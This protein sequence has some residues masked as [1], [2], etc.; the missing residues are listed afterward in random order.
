MAL[1]NRHKSIFILVVFWLF[2][3]AFNLT[4]AY[5]IDDTAHLETARAIQNDPLHPMSQT[6][7]WID[8]AEPIH[9]LNQPHL[10]FYLI[11][12]VVFLFGESEVILHLLLAIFSL[13]AIVFFFLIARAQSKSNALYLTALFCMA[14][15]FIPS[16]N[17][18]VDVPLLAIWLVFFWSLLIYVQRSDKG[19]VVAAM[20]ASCALLIKYSSLVLLPILVLEI[21]LRK[22]WKMLWTLTVPLLTLAVWSLFNYLDYGDVHLLS[23]E[24]VAYS[25]GRLF[26]RLVGWAICLGAITPFAPLLATTLW[27]QKGGRNFLLTS[28]AVAAVVCGL[29]LHL[30]DEPLNYSLLRAVFLANALFLLGML[31]AHALKVYRSR[32]HCVE[33]TRDLLLFAWLVGALLFIILF[34]PAIAV[35]HV[36]LIIPPTLLLLGKSLASISKRTLI[37]TVVLNT[38]FAI[39]FG[40]SDYVYADVYRHYAKGI[41]AKYA[42]A[43]AIWFTGHWGW[44][45]YAQQS[46][47]KEYDYLQTN[48]EDGDLLV[49]PDMVDKQKIKTEDFERLQKIDEIVVAGTAATFSRVGPMGGFYASSIRRLPWILSWE[50]VEKFIIYRYETL[51]ASQK[52]PTWHR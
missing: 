36:L 33:S 32:A 6:V 12:L 9:K 19:Y 22:K 3:T 10:F 40:V 30:A 41:K 17:L 24:P 5:H 44:K 39:L 31:A 37:L 35:R 50:P 7:N 46:G 20:A 13:L 47:M 48:L 43:N 51:G 34:A 15:A 28:L 49:A 42:K 21:A 18:M 1:R 2:V 16:Q 4:K 27:Q 38:A 25:A 11:A 52:T 45:W 29:G 8:T 23:R 14:P 26:I